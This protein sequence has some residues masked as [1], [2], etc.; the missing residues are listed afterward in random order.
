MNLYID[1]S[2]LVKFFHNE[3][4]TEKITELISSDNSICISEL[5]KLEFFSS[6]YRKYRARE[7]NDKMLA[8]AIEGFEEQIDKFLIE[9]IKSII[10]KEAELLLKKYGQNE[11]LRTLDSIHLATFSLI[12]EKNWIFVASDKRLCD[13]AEK[14][15]FKIINPL[16]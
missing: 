3:N 13:I 16:S 12:S 11:G 1:T 14:L 8:L 9:P 6:L 10:I 2:A 7:I 5:A 4:G 15:N